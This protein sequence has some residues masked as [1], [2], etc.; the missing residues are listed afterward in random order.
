MNSTVCSGSFI[1]L[2]LLHRIRGATR[3]VDRWMI[4]WMGR[5]EYGWMD[6]YVG[7][8]INRQTVSVPLS[9]NYPG[10]WRNKNK[11]S[12]WVHFKS[13]V[14]LPMK[15]AGQLWGSRSAMKALTSHRK[16]HVSPCRNRWIIAQYRNHA[17]RIMGTVIADLITCHM[18]A[19]GLS[20]EWES[21]QTLLKQ[22]FYS[23]LIIPTWRLAQMKASVAG[24]ENNEV[25]KFRV[26]GAW[27]PQGPHCYPTAGW[28][29]CLPVGEVWLREV[30]WRTLDGQHRLL[31]VCAYI[32]NTKV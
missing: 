27:V 17:A 5:W 16:V 1:F 19:E 29:V 20:W 15:K 31:I 4:T 6:R 12:I 24:K 18:L 26:H 13:G 2:R 14:A 7:W 8:W 32:N 22:R 10:R 3:W 21:M 23:T 9:G 30:G 25:I 11:N 28:V